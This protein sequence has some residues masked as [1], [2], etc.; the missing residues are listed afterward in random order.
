MDLD[1]NELQRLLDER[2][3]QRVLYRRARATD[4]RDLASALSCY[5]EDAT[6]DHEGFNGP[7]REYLSS[8]SPVFVGNSPVAINFH[9]IGN[10][11]IEV[12]GDRADCQSYFVCVLTVNEDS[13]ARDYMN[14]GRYLDAFERRGGVWAITHRQCVYD[15]SHGEPLTDKWWSRHDNKQA[16]ELQH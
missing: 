2:A 14:A 12:D 13:G 4:S 10:T 5:H 15:W 6:E 16:A 11:E 8:T 1:R 9:L 7:I 3:I